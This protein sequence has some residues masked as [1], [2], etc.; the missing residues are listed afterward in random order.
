ML[1]ESTDSSSL[2]VH[3]GGVTAAHDDFADVILGKLPLF[4]GVVVS[5]GCVLLLLAFRSIGSR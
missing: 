5:L 2:E 1:P 3:V 4:V